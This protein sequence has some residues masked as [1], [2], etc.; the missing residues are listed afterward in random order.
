MV[1]IIFF[2]NRWR[3]LICVL[4][5]TASATTAV[6]LLH[7][8]NKQVSGQVNGTAVSWLL[9]YLLGVGTLFVVSMLASVLLVKISTG[10]I[11]DIRIHLLH[12]II[13]T[14]IRSL[15]NT[16]K[17]ALLGVMT[18]DIDNLS[19]GLSDA[20]QFIMHSV[21]LMACFG[22]LAW[23]SPYVFAYFLTAVLVGGGITL[24]VLARGNVQ[25]K[26]YRSL[27]DNYYGYLHALF[28]GSK[29]LSTNV[30][31][32]RHFAQ[33]E[34][35][36]SVLA[37]KKSQVKWDIYWHLAQSWTSILLF[38]ALGVSIAAARYFHTDGTGLAVSY[39]VTIT[40][41][42]GAVDFVVHGV[43]TISKA[44]VSARVV[45]ALKLSSPQP[46]PVALPNAALTKWRQII[47]DNVCYTSCHRNGQRFDLGPI[48]LTLN[49]GE[50][51]FLVGGNGSGK[52]TFAK[53]MNGLYQRSSGTIRVDGELITAD[54]PD[55]YRALFST[56]YSDYYLFN[57]VLDNHGKPVSDGAIDDKLQELGLDHQVRTENGRWSS[58]ALSQ[59]QRK[60]L[61]LLQCWLDDSSIY[62]LDEWAA[63][64]DPGYRAHFYEVLLP[65]MHAQ[66][67]TLVV[68][69]HDERFFH[70]A[71]RVCIFD[72]GRVADITER[73]SSR[74]RA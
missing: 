63:D 16:G 7:Y 2:K 34:L 61:A 17:G 9:E 5:C 70:L 11:A 26:N 30:V 36:P 53:V 37:L 74:L 46:R 22:Y 3:L 4:L 48:N 1:K 73:H 28:D 54:T 45:S 12:G 14:D 69:T 24:M 35:F 64:Q 33:E 60:R 25:Y 6:L 65:A 38:I 43:S 27:K 57:S 32:R 13:S 51:L 72:G 50:I 20:P 52:S 29:E 18:D 44:I 58:T 47:F 19:N 42:A 39:F 23:L 71:D 8:L 21:T 41:V 68:I 66:G 56:I 15:E 59:G 49:R 55:E 67:K 40:F 10:A 31:R 62:V